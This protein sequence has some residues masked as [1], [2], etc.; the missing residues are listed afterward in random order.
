MMSP[1][2]NNG[3][4]YTPSWVVKLINDKTL[5][6]NLENISICDPSC[7]DGA[8]LSDVVERICQQAVDASNPAPYMKSLR[9]LT[10]F[11]VS[12]MALRDCKTKLNQIAK[13]Y[14]PRSRINWNLHLIDGINRNEWDRWS[15]AFDYV[16]GN[17]P[18]VRVQH[19]EKKRR[20]LISEQ[21]WH[22]IGGCTDLYM[23]FFEYGINLI[24]PGGS[25][26]FITPNS[27]MKSNAGRKFREYI[28]V[29]NL[30][31]IL[32]F[33]DVQVFDGFTTYTAITK[34]TKSQRY[35][36]PIVHKFVDGKITKGYKLLEYRGKL[37]CVKNSR[38]SILMKQS[39]SVLGD[40]ADIKV[41]I[42]TLADNVFILPVI[43]NVANFTFCDAS[44]EEIPIESGIIKKIY[45][46]SVMKDGVDRLNRVIIYPYDEKG[47][48]LPETFIKHQFPYAYA[49]LLE[50]KSALNLRDKGN[51]R[52]Y[53]WYE[54]GRGVG[55]TTAFGRK[56]LTSGMNKEPN[57]QMC[58]DADSLFYSGYSIKPKAGIDYDKL[59]NELNSESMNEYIIS[60]SKPFLHGWRSYAKSF[61]QDYPINSSIVSL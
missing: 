1:V 30:D 17:P 8:F 33:D 22:S 29:F 61:L 9:N 38:S 53:K 35:K 28:N 57:F 26:C 60:I 24:K 37:V 51:N 59:L 6:E 58:D 52:G 20:E 5:P 4:V 7:G 14:F 13:K 31:Y 2:K 19:L 27:W 16:I 50:N 45:K 44:G 55:I 10:G 49:W 42:Q 56:I 25:L 48:L 3:V 54:Y 12:F 40:I 21:S 23:L 46:A 41:G 32:D 15:N 18:Y 39:D 34:I 36:K 47:I 43:R 11:D